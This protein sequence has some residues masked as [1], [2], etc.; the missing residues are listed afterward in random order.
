GEDVELLMHEAA[1]SLATFTFSFDTPDL[2][3]G[4]DIYD[5]VAGQWL[6]NA[7]VDVVSPFDNTA[8]AD[9]TVEPS[10]IGLCGNCKTSAYLLNQPQASNGLSNDLRPNSGC[11]MA[12][13]NQ[14]GGV[15]TISQA[16]GVP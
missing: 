4:I 2:E 8:L 14:E 9:I 13:V 16:R 12:A 3:K 1:A 7:W 6:Y 11:L 10:E 15:L 5:P